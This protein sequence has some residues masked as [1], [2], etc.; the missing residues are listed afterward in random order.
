MHFNQIHVIT[1][2]LHDIRTFSKYRSIEI[3]L[4]PLQPFLAWKKE[5][6]NHLN[7]IDTIVHYS[8]PGKETGELYGSL[9]SKLSLAYYLYMGTIFKLGFNNVDTHTSIYRP[10]ASFSQ[11]TTTLQH[12]RQRPEGLFNYF[13]YIERFAEI[14]KRAI[15]RRLLFPFGGNG[16]RDMFASQKCLLRWLLLS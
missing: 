7:R 15:T 14:V 9:F 5:R 3:S 4:H 8:G 13:R 12:L 1:F 11:L 6:G 16:Q 2:S 10:G